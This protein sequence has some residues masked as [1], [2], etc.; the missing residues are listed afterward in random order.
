MAQHQRTPVFTALVEDVNGDDHGKGG[1]QRLMV[2]LVEPVDLDE[3]YVELLTAGV[4]FTPG[5]HGVDP[6][7]PSRSARHTTDGNGLA[8]L[9]VGDR[10]R[11][12]IAFDNV[13]AGP[14]AI[15]PIEEIEFRVTAA[16]GSS[17]WR[18][19]VKAPV[20][21]IQKRRKAAAIWAAMTTPL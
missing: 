2:Q 16:A 18:V 12:R 7:A 6:G 11:W 20:E 9:A 15:P 5:Q 17:R 8:P 1:W 3:V 21:A 4:A 13:E 10:T 19:L 14:D